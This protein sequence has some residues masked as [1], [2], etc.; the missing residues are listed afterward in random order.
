MIRRILLPVIS[1]AVVHVVAGQSPA[2][3]E[4][5]R[6]DAAS[7]VPCMRARV[8]PSAAG[9]IAAAQVDSTQIGAW[10]GTLAGNPLI[11]PGFAAHVSVLPTRLLVLIDR[12]PAMAGDGIA[13]TRI[14]LKSWLATLDSNS[15]RVAVAG[16]NG[17]DLA[18]RI[19]EAPFRAPNA[20]LASL[21][22]LPS[23]TPGG[24]SPLYSAA[25]LGA[26]RV[27]AARDSAPGSVG[28]VLIV[29]MGRNDVGRGK[30]AAGLLAG[31]TG[32]TAAANGVSA[33]GQRVWIMALDGNAPTDELGTLAG[34]G[35]SAA[36][37]SLD[38]NA[39]ANRLAA[40]SREFIAT[41]EWTFGVGAIGS[42]TLGRTAAFGSVRLRV[43]DRRIAVATLTWRPPLLAMPVFRAVAEPAALSPALREALLLGVGAGS[44]RPIVALLVAVLVAGAWLLA[45]RM[46]WRDFA[47]VAV[48]GSAGSTTTRTTTTSV[49]TEEGPPRRP[50]DITH[51]TA[52]RTALR[53]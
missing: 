30:A 2:R 41:R 18:A 6:C 13:F 27:A 44:N 48:T 10:S 45:V 23:P 28:G 12:G 37:I 17:G 51:Q 47:V 19:A 24:H 34:A 42:G 15:I 49:T 7:D 1:A 11:G 16:F 39:I 32:L 40:I 5:V 46:G 35:G 14:A 53:R 3:L 33:T 29:S 25:L 31:S 52:R 22:A 8:T 50:E 38:P 21:D 20:A 43:G 9:R 26:Q 36:A 4:L